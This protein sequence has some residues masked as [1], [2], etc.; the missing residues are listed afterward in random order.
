MPKHL[1][2]GSNPSQLRVKMSRKS[3]RDM[4]SA[5]HG[6]KKQSCGAQ[7]ALKPLLPRDSLDG[8]HGTL[9]NDAI[10]QAIVLGFSRR[11][12]EVPIRIQL[13]LI[14]RLTGSVS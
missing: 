3:H 7:A 2:S 13:N 11:H 8:M 5:L 6:G 10:N 12:K 14:Q 9:I 1:N 4:A